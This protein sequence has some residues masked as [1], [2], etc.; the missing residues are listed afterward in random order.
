MPRDALDS[1]A[2]TLAAPLDA[3]RARLLKRFGRQLSP[4][5]RDRAA[6]TTAIASVSVVACFALSVGMPLVLLALG[7]IL[8]GVPHLVADVR[9]LVVR[10]GLHTR[11][12]AQLALPLLLVLGVAVPTLELAGLATLFAAAVA[13][14]SFTRR[15]LTGA[16]GLVLLVLGRRLGHVADVVFAHLHNVLAVLLWW[17]MRPRDRPFEWAVPLLVAVL[18]LFFVLGPLPRT[19]DT[20]GGVISLP[21]LVQ[22]LAPGDAP[23]SALRFVLLFAFGQSV[24][25]A[26][27]LR[28]IPE[29]T[30]QR[31]AP[32]SHASSYR[33]LRAEI[34]ASAIMAAASITLALV[35]WSS[36]DLEG[37]RDAYLRLALFHGPLEVALLGLA[38]AEGRRP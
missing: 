17:S 23:E 18:S 1:L 6:R 10:R 36:M 33:A 37:A 22:S 24:H 14:G 31:D 34:G 21:S 20:F 29:D 13:R 5:F 19:F 2:L 27:W 8:L 30:R 25:Y 35:V 38:F 15:M 9:Y 11:R 26:L 16:S 32:R 3:G 28:A 12:G 4:L 7:P